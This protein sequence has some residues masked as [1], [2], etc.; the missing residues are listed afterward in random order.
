MKLTTAISVLQKDAD[1][2]GMNFLDFLKFVNTN[3]MAQTQ[4]T[5]AALHHP[6]GDDEARLV[7]AVVHVLKNT[8]HRVQT[9][10]LI[11]RVFE[12]SVGAVD[13]AQAGQVCRCHLGEKPLDVRDVCGWGLVLIQACGGVHGRGRVMRATSGKNHA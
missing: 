9:L 6:G 13:L 10:N 3:P 1:F 4:K 5:L 12:P 8:P 11:E 2:L 7:Q